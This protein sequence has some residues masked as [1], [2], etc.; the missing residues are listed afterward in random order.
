MTHQDVQARIAE[1]PEMCQ[2]WEAA[3]PIGDEGGM[4]Y[5][6]SIHRG[7]ESVGTVHVYIWDKKAMGEPELSCKSARE[8]MMRESLDRLV[9]E[10]DCHNF[11]AI[12]FAKRV[13]FKVIGVVRQRKDAHGKFH[14]VVLF[15]AL[16]GDLT[17]V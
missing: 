12:N 15:D 1:R 6:S 13:G 16:P 14:D 10:V 8:L 4:F 17:W 7:E 3:F 5:L 2:N 9:G 11:L